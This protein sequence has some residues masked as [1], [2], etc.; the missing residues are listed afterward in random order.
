MKC[1]LKEIGDRST[2]RST[3]H[4]QLFS[5]VKLLPLSVTVCSCYGHRENIE[6][7]S[8]LCLG[9]VVCPL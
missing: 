2:G 7:I 3:E 8:A 6:N 5:Q 1:E 4:N 9:G